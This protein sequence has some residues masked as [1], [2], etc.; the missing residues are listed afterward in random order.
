MSS[1]SAF[2]PPSSSS[3]P[4]HSMDSEYPQ[5]PSPVMPL[6]STLNLSSASLPSPFIP[7]GSLLFPNY[8]DFDD[9]DT[10]LGS[11]TFNAKQTA[12]LPSQNSERSSPPM[13]RGLAS[14]MCARN[15]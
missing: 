1:S 2:A 11:L 4:L 12:Q 9:E 8:D 14:C 5:A 6:R 13:V 3:V 7:P 15:P 10:E